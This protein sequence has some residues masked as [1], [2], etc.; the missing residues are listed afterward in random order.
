[1]DLQQPLFRAF[2]IIVQQIY[3]KITNVTLMILLLLMRLMSTYLAKK[4]FMD[5][6]SKCRC[7]CLTA[8]NSKAINVEQNILSLFEFQLLRR[9][10]INVLYMIINVM[11]WWN[12][13]KYNYQ[14]NERDRQQLWKHSRQNEF[15]FL[16]YSEQQ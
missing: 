10:V 7:I 6:I 15:R 8:T 14:E 9:T 5:L 4:I 3:C 12:S 13:V 16:K 1:L 11:H 2:D